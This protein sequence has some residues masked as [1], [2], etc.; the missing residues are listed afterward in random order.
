ME[1]LVIA[2][3]IQVLI[4]LIEDFLVVFA[5]LISVK[6]VEESKKHLKGH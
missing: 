5:V 2:K 1:G 3:A 4:V 6:I